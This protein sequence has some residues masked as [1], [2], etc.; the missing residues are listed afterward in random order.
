MSGV[1]DKF[2]AGLSRTRKGIFGKLTQ[3]FSGKSRID[4]TLLEDLEEAL[5]EA[6]VGVD[7]S[8]K[9]VDELKNSLSGREIKPDDVKNILEEKIVEAVSINN[10]DI[11]VHEKPHVI[12]VTGVNGSGKT[13]T[14]GKLA[15][16]Y[17]KEGKKVLLAGADTFRAAAAEQLAEWSRR[18][19]AD[20]IFQ[21]HGADPASVAYDALEAASARGVDLVLI[22]TAGRLQNKVNLMEE[23]RKIQRVINK[24][25]PGAPHEVLLVLDATTGQN[26]LVQAKIFTEAVGVTGIVLTKLDGT[27]RGGIVISICTNLGIPIVW[28][29]LGESIDDLVKFDGPLFVDGL[30]EKE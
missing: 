2:S 28:A 22:D 17:K 4:N 23:L 16:I 26:G 19:N 13:T 24:R 3:M 18:T 21:K 20:I 27:A 12:L 15:H 6:D 11:S 9:I 14:I 10:K 29:G 1:E 8:L 30:F 7:L 5:I 25:M